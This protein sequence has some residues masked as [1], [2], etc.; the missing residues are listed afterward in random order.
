MGKKIMALL[1]LL[2]V[3]PVAAPFSVKAVDGGAPQV[4]GKGVVVMEAV[5][6]RVLFAQ[7][8][9]EQ[10][11][12]ASTTKILTALIT[13]EQPDQDTYFTVDSTAIPGNSL[14]KEF[15]GGSL[16]QV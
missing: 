7:G 13:L 16:F 11:A 5:S 9:Q 4:D 14:L 3:L 15:I 10:L 12:M 2:L 6:G 8:A 1:A